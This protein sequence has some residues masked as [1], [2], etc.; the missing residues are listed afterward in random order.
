MDIV[1]TNPEFPKL[2]ALIVNS[3][4]AFAFAVAGLAN[5][6]NVGN[7]GA[8][9]KRWGYPKGWRFVTAGLEL[10]A[11]ACLLVQSTRLIAIVGLALLMVAAVATLMKAREPIPKVVPAVIFLAMVL[12]DAVLQLAGT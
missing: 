5:L 3:V 7:A 6:F 11:A 4:T 12:G 1:L 9:F 10:F 2:S 8:S